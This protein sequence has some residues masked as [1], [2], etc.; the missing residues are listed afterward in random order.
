MPCIDLLAASKVVFGNL[1]EEVKQEDSG[2][3]DVGIYQIKP[4]PP[5]LPSSKIALKVNSRLVVFQI[6][7]HLQ[8]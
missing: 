4:N 3:T 2:S 6:V 1:W 7:L 5:S 8:F